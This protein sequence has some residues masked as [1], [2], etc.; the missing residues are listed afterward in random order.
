MAN[1]DEEIAKAIAQMQEACDRARGYAD[2]FDYPPDRDIAEVGA[3]ES[4]AE[5]LASDGAE[6][7][8]DLQGRGR[9]NDPPDCEALN[10]AG[11]RIAIEVTELV[12]AEAI[13]ATKS[14]NVVCWREW[15]EPALLSRLR[16]ALNAKDGKYP[17]LKGGPY[18]GGY[19]VVI[20]T[21]E[22]LLST[23]LVQSAIDQQT[24]SVE[25]ISRAFLLL[26]YRSGQC[27]YFELALLRAKS[28]GG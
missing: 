21:D 13:R 26:S 6:F 8:T 9:G 16:D 28:S 7:F 18:L 25:H 20:H 19:V 11:E 10:S 5:S 1:G 27:P 17:K 15:D 3:V 22:P 2:F 23:E 4:L 24:F 14:S 12:S